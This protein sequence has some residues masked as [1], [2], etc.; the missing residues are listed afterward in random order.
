LEILG[1][2]SGSIIRFDFISFPIAEN[3]NLTAQNKM[4]F[5]KPN[6]IVAVNVTRTTGTPTFPLVP[7]AKS[8]GTHVLRKERIKSESSVEQKR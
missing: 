7:N 3:L 8:A 1:F 2:V 6:G 5:I 4:P